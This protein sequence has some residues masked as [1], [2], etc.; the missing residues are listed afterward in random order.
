MS[1]REKSN[2]SWMRGYLR[3]EPSWKQVA[4]VISAVFG[5]DPG[6]ALPWPHRE[7]EADGVRKDRRMG[8]WQQ[9][10]DCR[11]TG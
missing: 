7:G 6:M 1:V 2:S 3:Q 4:A 9:C 5:G 11:E 8:W 10:W